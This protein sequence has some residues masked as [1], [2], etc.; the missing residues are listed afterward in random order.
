[1]TPKKHTKPNMNIYN[2]S[3][4]S[5]LYALLKKRPFFKVEETKSGEHI[6]ILNTQQHAGSSA[7]TERPILLPNDPFYD[8]INTG[9]CSNVSLAKVGL[10]QAKKIRLMSSLYMSGARRFFESYTNGSKRYLVK[11]Q[12]I[13]KDVAKVCSSLKQDVYFL[14]L[15]YNFKELGA[16]RLDAWASYTSQIDGVLRALKKKYNC[17]YER[18]TESTKKGYPHAH[19]ILYFDRATFPTL[20]SLRPKTKIRFGELYD[21]IRERVAS[22]QFLL[23]KGAADKCISYI[24]K[25]IGKAAETDLKEL[26]KKP[27]EWTGSDRKNIAT[28]LFPIMSHTRR[29]AYT[30]TRAVRAGIEELRA[31]IKREKKERAQSVQAT[32]KKEKVATLSLSLPN[33]DDLEKPLTIEECER[34]LSRTATRGAFLIWLCTKVAPN[35][36]REVK[37]T[38]SVYAADNFIKS[39]KIEDIPPEELGLFAETNMQSVYKIPQIL[40]AFVENGG[41]LGESFIYKEFDI[42]LLRSW[43]PDTF[44]EQS[45]FV[46]ICMNWLPYSE[47]A[48]PY[49]AE[50]CEVAGDTLFRAFMSNKLSLEKFSDLVTELKTIYN[51][52]DRWAREREK[53][54]S[55]LAEYVGKEKIVDPLEALEAHHLILQQQAIL[56]EESEARQ[57]HCLA[58]GALIK[59]LKE[60]L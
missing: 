39:R 59:V 46:R 13:L 6:A 10:R 35:A 18:V 60:I 37:I 41:E 16:E 4:S 9:L 51:D 12:A 52:V 30:N 55:A 53:E 44:R 14:T 1:M 45:Q 32:E 11:K 17:F 48:A 58:W 33:V 49:F 8:D 42:S 15:T 2:V 20:E 31:G 21:F 57:L 25:Y 26:V 24:T 29:F 23:E 38:S 22:P 7:K 54:L 50:D 34:Y 3:L 5:C 47:I 28:L 56:N 36:N 40:K 27:L 19:I 43:T